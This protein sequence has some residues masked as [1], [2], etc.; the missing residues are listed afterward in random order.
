[1]QTR[2][3]SNDPRPSC[4]EQVC[5]NVD[6]MILWVGGTGGLGVQQYGG[7]AALQEPPEKYDIIL[8]DSR[9]PVSV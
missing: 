6:L 5:T 8:M 7:N 1:M 4:L 9:A 3:P 2:R